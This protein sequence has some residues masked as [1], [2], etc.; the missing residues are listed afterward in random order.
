MRFRH[1][2]RLVAAA[3]LILILGGPG[4]ARIGPS[5]LEF[6]KV[7]EWASR[8]ARGEAYLGKVI[9]VRYEPYAVEPPEVYHP[10]LLEL[11]D[12]IKTPLRSGYRLVLKGYTDASG[13]RGA[14]LRISRMRADTLK[15]VLIDRYYMEPTRITAEGHGSADPV[16]SND[17]AAGRSLNR[18][19]EIHVY[20][21]PSQAVRFMSP[22]EGRGE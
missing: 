12:V 6:L 8:H 16:A 7:W 13:D 14:N 15:Q 21:D 9:T 11:T 3:G 19:V 20:G 1:T 18:R 22:A 5:P 2:A 17:T 4:L 10:Y